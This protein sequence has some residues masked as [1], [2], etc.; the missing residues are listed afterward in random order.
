M[1]YFKEIRLIKCLFKL[2]LMVI[3]LMEIGRS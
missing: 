3:D 1:D 2:L